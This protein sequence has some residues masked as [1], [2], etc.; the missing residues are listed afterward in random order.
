MMKTIR[1][2]ESVRSFSS[3]DWIFCVI[4]VWIT[5]FYS[6]IIQYKY[7]EIPNGMLITGMLVLATFIFTCTRQKF[8]LERIFTKECLWMIGFMIYMLPIGFFTSPDINDHVS[9][10]VTGMEYMF[11][12]IVL[13]SVIMDNGTDSF[14][15]MLLIISIVLAVIFLRDPVLYV[16]G[17]RYS[18]SKKVNPNGLGMSFT[19]G[20]WVMLYIQQKKK[21]PVLV[22]ITATALL[23]YCI[24][25]TG[26]RKAL[27]AA[28]IIIVLWYAFAYLPKILR[29]GGGWQVAILLVSVLL[30]VFLGK[31]FLQFYSGSDIQARM[32]GL[33]EEVSGGKRA[34][35]YQQ[36]WNLFKTN[37]LF[38]IGFQGY[39]YYFGGYSHATLVE[40]PVSGGII[41]TVI[42]FAAYYISIAK[43][44]TLYRQCRKR[45]KLLIHAM[46]IKMII[47]LWIAMLFY[48]SCI[49]HPYQFDSYI[50]FGIIFGETSHIEK[51]IL[52]LPREEKKLMERKCKWIR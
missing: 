29:N 32:E 15:V 51:E 24:F 6:V 30:L 4:S 36:G 3:N 33:S 18:I 20:I 12:M 21:I 19:T 49:I 14:H 52:S 10:W 17:G 1:T 43:C 23:L 5:V 16:S 44:V 34:S 9:Q 28:G 47:I 45:E 46:E 25:K 38:G 37:P 2:Q 40:I 27:I 22:S 11:M 7:K 35:L 48:C 31:E 26:S 13:S 39:G 8:T 42:Y 41:G 50:I